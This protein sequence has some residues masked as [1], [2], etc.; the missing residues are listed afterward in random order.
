MKLNITV[1]ETVYHDFEVDTDEYHDKTVFEIAERINN[2]KNETSGY[3]YQNTQHR[4]V[5]ELSDLEIKEI[6]LTNK[7]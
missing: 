1:K 2:I 5:G 7:I 6:K 3:I 4:V